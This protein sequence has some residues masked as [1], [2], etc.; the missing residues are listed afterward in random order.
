MG[1]EKQNKKR[2]RERENK[3][4]KDEIIY[5]ISSWKYENTHT[6]THTLKVAL[7][8][9]SLGCVPDETWVLETQVHGH[10]QMT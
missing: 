8:S 1:L 6:Q 10:A 3:V 2:E 9:I 4:G 7:S 5:A